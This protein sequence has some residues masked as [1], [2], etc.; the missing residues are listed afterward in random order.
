M[1]YEI[2]RERE[3]GWYLTERAR[4]LKYAVARYWDGEDWCA[5]PNDRDEYDS[6]RDS[7]INVVS[8]KLPYNEY[9]KGLE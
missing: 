3:I 1:N 9:L 7:S 5:V 2:K 6:I 8:D 4:N